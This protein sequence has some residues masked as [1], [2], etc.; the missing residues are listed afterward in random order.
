MLVKFKPEILT[1]KLPLIK[2]EHG[3]A[4]AVSP[5]DLKRWLDAGHDD[6]GKPIV[7]LDTRN[8]FEIDVGSFNNMVDYRIEKFSD[9]P[10]AVKGRANEFRG[11]TVVTF[12]TGGIRC[13][14]AA[15]HMQELGFDSVYQLDGG[16]LNY[17]E[18]VGMSHYSGDCFVFDHRTALN[19]A[20]VPALAAICPACRSE[21]T[22]REQL[23]SSYIPGEHCPHCR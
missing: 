13:E 14:K 22:P 11:K 21:V 20:L 15:I 5:R 16:I 2:P 17:F 6:Q 7:M 8:A 12:C 18:E 1:M 4:P 3:R 23:A 10:D 9:F 19:A